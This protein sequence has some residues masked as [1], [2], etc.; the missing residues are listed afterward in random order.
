GYFQDS[1]IST[2]GSYRYYNAVI[3]IP[4][5]SFAEFLNG[6]EASGNVTYYHENTKDITDTYSDISARVTSLKAEEAK[7]LEFYK[8]AESLDD[9]LRIESRL[10]DIR[11]EIDYLETQLKNFDLQVAYSTLTISIRETTTYTETNDSFWYRLANSF[12]YGWNDFVSGIEDFVLD[13]V[14]Y[15]WNILL[16]A[17]IIFGAYKLYRYIRNRRNK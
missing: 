5:E 12:K 15:L 10:T 1:S 6:V 8:D 7:V 11:Y 16:F 13:V 9:L 4:A 17:A 3:R 14:Y 2:S